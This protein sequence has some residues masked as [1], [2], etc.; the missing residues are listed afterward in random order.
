MKK[1]A[2]PDKELTER[3]SDYEFGELVKSWQF[4]ENFVS[5]FGE[6]SFRMTS[7]R[8]VR[9]KMRAQLAMRDGER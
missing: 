6:T 4:L 2:A 8:S 1:A 9:R 5:W 3:M 7:L